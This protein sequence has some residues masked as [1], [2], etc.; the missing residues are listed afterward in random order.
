[1]NQ[2][3]RSKYNEIM[4][5]AGSRQTSVHKAMVGV[6]IVEEENASPT[7][8]E[9]SG[10]EGAEGESSEQNAAPEGAVSPEAS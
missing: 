1:M 9:G 5:A 10:G 7:S 8:G 6:E 3:T 2:L 4:N